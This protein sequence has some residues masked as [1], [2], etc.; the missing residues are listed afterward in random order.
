MTTERSKNRIGQLV[1]STEVSHMMP[2]QR[3]WDGVPPPTQG[4]FKLQ[5]TPM[6]APRPY[7]L[8]PASKAPD[9]VSAIPHLSNAPHPSRYVGR[10]YSGPEDVFFLK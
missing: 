8:M 6:P 3:G 5:A 1:S 4:D 9:Y 7:E 2:I 10:A